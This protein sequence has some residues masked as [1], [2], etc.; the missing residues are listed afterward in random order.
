V[1][2]YSGSSSSGRT[3]YGLLDHESEDT[4]TGGGGRGGSSSS[5]GGGSTVTT[6]P[7]ITNVTICMDRVQLSS[8][9]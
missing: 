4:T 9:S 7:T 1:P 3:L 5:S 2:S 6:I 8:M